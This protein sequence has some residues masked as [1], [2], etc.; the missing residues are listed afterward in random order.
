MRARRSAFTLLELLVVIAIIAVLVALLVPAII[1]AREAANRCRCA[2]NLHQIGLAWHMYEQTNDTLPYGSWPYELL[3]YIEQDNWDWESPLSLYYCPSRGTPSA[4]S[5]RRDYAGGR[6]PM[7]A[8]QIPTFACITDGLSN[9]MFLSE[10]NM[11]LGGIANS[12]DPNYVY[13]YDSMGLFNSGYL[14]YDSGR[15]PA[16]DTAN[17][18][19]VLPTSTLTA[20]NSY[21]DANGNP[22]NTQNYYA[23]ATVGTAGTPSYYYIVL[24]NFTNPGQSVSVNYPTDPSSLGF[25]STHPTAMNML[26]CD[27]S[28]HRYRYGAPGLTN[29][30]QGNDGNAVVIPE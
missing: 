21:Y 15:A 9:T 13:V 17:A 1:Q 26:M 4:N 6:L 2:N 7:S 14:N 3:S 10:A 12:Y 18:D 20:P 28:V 16:Q 30:I 23:T 11:P 5:V 22:G 19:M 27:G 25:G 24:Y 8:I 29:I